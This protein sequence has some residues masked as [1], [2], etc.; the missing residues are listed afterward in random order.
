MQSS[1]KFLFINTQN[2]QNRVLEEI[3]SKNQ[4]LEVNNLKDTIQFFE[5][6]K[7]EFVL[8]Y[9]KYQEYQKFLEYQKSF[10]KIPHLILINAN[11]DILDY[12]ELKIKNKNY[13]NI[14]DLNPDILSKSIKHLLRKTN[15]DYLESKSKNIY[16]FL[17]DNAGDSIFIIEN[18][19]FVDCNQMTLT[20][21]G[22]N[23]ISEI[24]GHTPWEFSPEYQEDG[25]PS[26]KKAIS[27]INQAKRKKSVKFYWLHKRKD[28]EIFDAEVNLSFLKYEGKER[29]LAIVRDIS[30]QIKL[31][32]IIKKNE[33]HLTKVLNSSPEGIF[34][35]DL[36]FCILSC[37]DATV[38][39]LGAN[40]QKDIIGMDANIFIHPDDINTYNAA[41]ET[42]LNEENVRNIE[43][44]IKKLNGKNSMVNLSAQLLYNEQGEPESIIT[45]A[46]DISTRV[47][48][49]K[50]LKDSEAKNKALS[51][52]TREAVLF[53]KDGYII[54]TN[55]AT[56]IMF[57][58]THDELIGMFGSELVEESHREAVKNN[59]LKGYDEP[60]E[61]L[62]ITKD[63]IK[64]WVEF[65]GKMFNYKGE[66]IRVI[67]I[68][69]VDIQKRTMIEL[70]KAKE[71]AEEPD[72]LKSA[73]LATMSHELRTPLNA[74][75]GFSDLFN[76]ELNKQDMVRFARTI[77]ESGKHL[78]AIIENI[79]NISLI[80][81]GKIQLNPE[82]ADLK[83]FLEEINKI[84]KYKL[85]KNNKDNLIKI[86]GFS[87][88]KLKNSFRTFDLY[89]ARQIIDQLIEN[90]IKFTPKGK[91]EMNFNL[92]KKFFIVSIKDTGIGISNKD[93]SYIFDWFRQVD[94]SHTREYGGTGLGL[95]IAKKLTD[96]MNGD[97]W[98]E[99][100][101]NKGA[102][103]FVKI[104]FMDDVETVIA[105]DKSSKVSNEAN[106]ILVA[107]DEESNYLYLKTIIE[108]IQA[109]VV[110]A[111]NG[112]EALDIIKKDQDFNLILMDVKMPVL[113]G[114]EASR[115][116]LKI[117]KNIPIIAQTAYAML[118]DKERAL[119]V[120]CM[121]YISKP[122]KK[123]KLVKIIETY[124]R[125]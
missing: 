41:K 77:N 66:K 111:W 75:I 119:E 43:I 74:I 63:R 23:K 95:T 39:M 108:N 69:D 64:F 14:N 58:Y 21:F 54:E 122:I 12:S 73:F 46:S 55:E 57:N 45:V 26:I 16:K 5:Q 10:L 115:E 3:L 110:H 7:I 2:F 91:I 72:R 84:A 124:I 60:Y 107:E 1:P 82:N 97:I 90:A 96:L 35:L 93:Q 99:S 67:T 123:E 94:D 79:L 36:N 6:Y 81:T 92:G 32:K 52:S 120:G 125:I 104:P 65:H 100:E 59:M 37:N 70:Q 15:P 33:E 85:R 68:K 47:L 18:D 98:L 31:D 71:K 112:Q 62:A 117:T 113:N 49:E 89:K 88:S 48:I 17:F 13:L 103:F 8:I 53:L 83:V 19:T 28:G 87:L 27:Y 24:I 105:L 51:Q 102:T 116:I 42:L 78:L 86:Q 106:R 29:G 109:E 61:S 22:L 80:E 20:M 121:D 25:T 11:K 30:D 38:K 9:V 34:S 40:Q 44:R 101:K 4:F 114:F 50:A 76:N 56:S 118:G